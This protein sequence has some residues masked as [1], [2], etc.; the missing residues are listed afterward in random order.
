MCSACCT[1]GA[2]ETRRAWSRTAWQLQTECFGVRVIMGI[3]TWIVLGIIAGYLGRWIMSGDQKMGFVKTAAFGVLGALLGGFV[4]SM[5]GIGSVERAGLKEHFVGVGGR[6]LCPCGSGPVWAVASTHSPGP[7]PAAFIFL[8]CCSGPQ[9]YAG[10][11][12]QCGASSRQLT[13]GTPHLP[14]PVEP[15]SILSVGQ[16][17][18]PVKSARVRAIAAPDHRAPRKS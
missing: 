5:L 16:C 17:P 3:M 4:G 8:R 6:G 18:V 7:F 13:T 1:S 2:A 10:Y 9:A 15:D 11:I 12:L 14:V